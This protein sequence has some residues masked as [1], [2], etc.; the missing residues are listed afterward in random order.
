MLVTIAEIRSTQILVAKEFENLEHF[1][2]V[3]RKSANIKFLNF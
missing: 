2:Q 1:K 3:S